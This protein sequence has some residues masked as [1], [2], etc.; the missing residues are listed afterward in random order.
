MEN[1]RPFT[2]LFSLIYNFNLHSSFGVFMLYAAV[3]QAFNFSVNWQL[4]FMLALAIPPVYMADH[5]FDNQNK[6]QPKRNRLIY[7]L[8]GV[9]SALG[10]AYLF[11][12]LDY[13]LQK[14]LLVPA[15]LSLTYFSVY[16]LGWKN[17]ESGLVKKIL[18]ASKNII[19]ASVFF[20]IVVFVP[21]FSNSSSIYLMPLLFMVLFQNLLVFSFLDAADD[22]EYKK[23]NGFNLPFFKK[24]TKKIGLA[25]FLICGFMASF[26]HIYNTTS[27]VFV[28]C[29]FLVSIVYLTILFLEETGSVTKIRFIADLLLALPAF[30]LL[31]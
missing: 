9:S 28:F 25:S 6:E 7:W 12:L 5:W 2:A 17:I 20:L 14:R 26:S 16:V 8:T 1:R 31:F 18:S 15:L 27:P 30:S 19:I 13:P 23:P 22:D 29:L 21:D 3:Q 4:C 10:A 24:N 11:L